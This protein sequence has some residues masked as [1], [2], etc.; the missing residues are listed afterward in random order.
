MTSESQYCQVPGGRGEKGKV[1]AGLWEAA[2]FS[3]STDYRKDF[4]DAETP[5]RTI[6][7]NQRQQRNNI[8]QAP[9]LTEEMGTSVG[10]QQWRASRCHLNSFS[11]ATD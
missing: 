9:R 6:G 8:L 10:W 2:T 4:P 3:N 1:L 5:S 7:Q 11:R